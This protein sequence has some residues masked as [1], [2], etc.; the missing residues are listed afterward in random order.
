VIPAILGLLVIAVFAAAL[1]VPRCLFP[2]RGP[3]AAGAAAVPPVRVPAAGGMAVLA[4]T[5]QPRGEM[6]GPFAYD[7]G[8]MI[9]GEGQ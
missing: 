1:F 4:V 2:R 9:G 3:Q 7:N 8:L 5:V 6:T